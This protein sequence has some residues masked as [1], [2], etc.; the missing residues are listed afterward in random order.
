VLIIATAL[1]LRA[2]SHLAVRQVEGLI[3]SLLQL[4]GLDLPMLAHSILNRQPETLKVLRSKAG[5]ASV[6]LLVDSTGL[7]LCRPG[8]WRDGK[9]GTRRRQAWRV[10]HLATDADTGDIAALVLTDRDADDGS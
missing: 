10:L 5:S 9:H 6:H 8:A 4:L 7:F 2:V 3:A 1:T